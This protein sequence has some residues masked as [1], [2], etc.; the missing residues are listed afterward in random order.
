MCSTDT[1]TLFSDYISPYCNPP[2]AVVTGLPPIPPNACCNHVFPPAVTTSLPTQD[3]TNGSWSFC[4]SI[5]QNGTDPDTEI[6]F[7]TNWLG[8]GRCVAPISVPWGWHLYS[9]SGTTWD[10]KLDSL[11]SSDSLGCRTYDWCFQTCDCQENMAFVNDIHITMT[12][13]TPV[14]ETVNFP[15][16]ILGHCCGGDT[17]TS[18][19]SND[20]VTVTGVTPTCVDVTFHNSHYAAGQTDGCCSGGDVAFTFVLPPGC[21]LLSATLPSGWCYTMFDSLLE[22]NPCPSSGASI[23]CCGTLTVQICTD[24]PIGF[25]NWTTNWT[26]SDACDNNMGDTVSYC[27]GC[28]GGM[29]PAIPQSGPASK[30]EGSQNFPN[31]FGNGTNFTT[32]IPFI[33]SATGVATIRAVDEKGNVMLTEDQDVNYIGTHFFYFTGKDLPSG[34]YYY[35]IEFPKGVVIVNRSMLLVK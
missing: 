21:S 28:D 26:S 20:Y 34:T 27:G 15:V 30:D 23:T 32:T 2:T 17:T 7:N 9:Q 25:S 13:T 10:Y 4:I 22:I 8:L 3:P 16:G 24:C 11:Q 6:S 19:H 29:K 33:T 31:P 35:Q 18:W 5:H 14:D 1:I 12:G